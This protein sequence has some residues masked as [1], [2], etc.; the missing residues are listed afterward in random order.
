[1]L[2]NRGISFCILKS[3]DCYKKTP[4]SAG[5][6]IELLGN[7][8]IIPSVGI[9]VIVTNHFRFLADGSD[10][11]GVVLVVEHGDGVDA[12]AVGGGDWS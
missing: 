7:H 9:V 4:T 3:D 12:N 5:V 1:M 2:Q 6:K 8:A 10:F 11:V